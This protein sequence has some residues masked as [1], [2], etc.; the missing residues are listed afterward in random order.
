[1]LSARPAAAHDLWIEPSTFFATPGAVVALRLRV[2]QD[3]LGE[4]VPR[5]PAA[6]ERF[7]QA[8]DKATR[9]VPGRDGG[10]PAGL[11]SIGA[12][13]MTV[14]GYRTRPGAVTLP[15][16][17]FTQYLHEEGLEAIVAE[18]AARGQTNADGRELFSRA[19][20]SLLFA[21]GPANGPDRDRVLGF[22]L[23]LI[24]QGSPYVA[25]DREALGFQLLFESR[26]LAGVLV[27]AVNKKDPSLKQAQ[28]TD[29]KGRVSFDVSR[30]G[31]WLIKAVHM[32]PAPAGSGADWESIWASLTFESSEGPRP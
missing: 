30:Q 26:P 23:E 27:V 1:V 15:A 29:A 4:P 24:A 25:R 2:G 14:V 13:G 7:V 22:R 11:M 18:R 17:K 10:D 19:A 5:D 31:L 20:K 9:P 32:V 21:S 6:I 28:R 12:T 3:L 8:D 16:A